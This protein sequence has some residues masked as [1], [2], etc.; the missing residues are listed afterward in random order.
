MT[1]DDQVVLVTGASRGLGN[2]FARCLAAA[3]ATVAVNSTG[4]TDLGPQAVDAIRALGGNAV[5]V[6]GN[7]Q[8]AA[9]LVAEVVETCGRI[10]SIVHN[11]GIV[12]D[13]TLRK[14]S[15][16]QWDTVLDVHLKASFRLAKAA[17]PH[18]DAQGRR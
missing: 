4:A 18:F 7:V 10:D 13:K 1:F 11:A 6:P 12:L 15:E 5:H 14:M 17:W 8:D 16:Q 9:R 2:A 3:G